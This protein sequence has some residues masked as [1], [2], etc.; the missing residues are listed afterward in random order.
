[1]EGS[2]S[3]LESFRSG[4]DEL[5][6]RMQASL[7]E[8][9]E[10]TSAIGGAVGDMREMSDSLKTQSESAAHIAASMAGFTEAVNL[11][12][13][14]S[15]LIK[16]NLRRQK[17]S[18][19]A[20]LR[21]GSLLKGSISEMTRAVA[22]LVGGEAA[23]AVITIGH[24]VTYP[25]WVHIAG[26]RSAGIAIEVARHLVGAEGL[27]PEFRPGQFADAL[28]DLFA[29]K[30]R[31]LA[32]VG[33]PNAYFDDKPIIPTVPFTSFKPVIFG[34]ARRAG[35]LGSMA[36][37]AGKRVAAQRGSYVMGCLKDR[38]CEIVVTDNDLEAFAAVIW[39]RA[40]YAIT[41]RLVG[42]FLSRE[43]FSGMLVPVL[44]A[45]GSLSVVFILGK[46]DTA[47]RDRMDA[48]I[49]S[50]GTRALVDGLVA[51]HAGEAG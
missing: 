8:Q 10:G 22:S 44:D 29:G 49:K 37:L 18:A 5:T 27:V 1:M 47:L 30:V 20:V 23:E 48:L 31:I 51:R 26:G 21:T 36:D 12:T 19:A 4:K 15:E 24:D 3:G 40:D 14:S 35:A 7:R 43:Y 34:H 28:E 45:G 33:W 11:L 39:Q 46:S 16:G 25:P 42:A 6:R 9:R 38:G 13:E 41:E 50:P 17:D 32:N 2:R